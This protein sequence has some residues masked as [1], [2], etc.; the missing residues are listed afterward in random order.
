MLITTCFTLGS[1]GFLNRYLCNVH[2]TPYVC[3]PQEQFT[4]D[5]FPFPLMI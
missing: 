2:D 1:G 5:T 3:L 4:F